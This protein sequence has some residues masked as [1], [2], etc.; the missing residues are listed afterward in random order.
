LKVWVSSFNKLILKVLV[1]SFLQCILKVLVSKFTS[2][3]LINFDKGGVGVVVVKLAA[4]LGWN[5]PIP[6]SLQMALSNLA[7]YFND[8]LIHWCVQ[9][10]PLRSRA[11]AIWTLVIDPPNFSLSLSLSLSFTRPVLQTFSLSTYQYPG[12]ESS[13]SSLKSKQSSTQSFH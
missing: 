5:T 10:D 6:C 13:P 3:S 9:T 1:S 2:V 8:C 11:A 4:Y 7:M 12:Q